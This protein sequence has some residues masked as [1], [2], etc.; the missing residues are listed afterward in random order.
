MV[1][2]AVIGEKRGVP[3]LF[4]ISR[5]LFKFLFQSD[6]SRC[7]RTVRIQRKGHAIANVYNRIKL[8]IFRTTLHISVT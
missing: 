8:H 6:K 5:D 1:T 3:R 7:L 2:E 4:R